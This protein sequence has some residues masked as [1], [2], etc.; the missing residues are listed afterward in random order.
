MI[1]DVDN[2]SHAASNY[3]LKISLLPT[4]FAGETRSIDSTS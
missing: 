2:I 4:D 1:K 3:S